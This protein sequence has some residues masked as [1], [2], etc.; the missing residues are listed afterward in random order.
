MPKPAPKDFDSAPAPA[1]AGAG[2]AQRRRPALT[3]KDYR[4]NG[5]GR[6]SRRIGPSVDRRTGSCSDTTVRE[7][8][9]RR[10][11]SAPRA[12][13]RQLSTTAFCTNIH[14]GN[15]CTRASWTGNAGHDRVCPNEGPVGSCAPA[16]WSAL[17]E[18]IAPSD[19]SER[20]DG[21]EPFEWTAPS[22]GTEP[23]DGD[24]PS[25]RN[26]PFARA[27]PGGSAD[28]RPD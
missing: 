1:S 25:D 21:N 23:V 11:R 18:S 26:E 6:R 16:G 15:G 5:R 12:P 14:R 24:G 9:H 4:N 22:G 7:R 28:E 10:H 2:C 19:S 27:S 8:L 20:V 13:Q 3:C 17:F